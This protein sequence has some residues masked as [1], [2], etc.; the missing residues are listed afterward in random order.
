MS[1]ARARILS[2]NDEKILKKEMRPLWDAKYAGK[3]IALLLGFGEP[4]KYENLKPESVYNYRQKFGFPKR[5]D[6]VHY[7]HRYKF[8]RQ[9]EPINAVDFVSRVEGLPNLTFHHRRRRA[10]NIA[11]F[12]MFL[13]QGELRI[14]TRADIKIE[15]D[16]VRINAFRLK[17]GRHLTK[18]QATRPVILRTYWRLV[19]E[20]VEWI[21]RF[22]GDEKIFK[23]SSTTAWNYV[24]AIYPKGYPHYYRLS[25]I[26]DMCNNLN[27]TLIE[28]RNWTFLH[29]ITIQKYMS[30]SDRFVDAASEKMDYPREME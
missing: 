8:G 19:P 16:R 28:I 21:N 20:L 18:Q 24:K 10:F 7:P 27:M 30:E 15:G 6:R 14:L 2:E 17:K 26:T 4:G 11:A 13:R 3:D 12:Y 22:K 25:G 1:F 23:I 5:Y 9:E 29:L